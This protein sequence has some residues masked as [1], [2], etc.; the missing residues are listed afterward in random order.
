M[1]NAIILNWQIYFFSD[2]DLAVDSFSKLQKV[3]PYRLE[4]MD[5][6]SN[7]LYVKVSGEI[8]TENCLNAK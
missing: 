6:Y 8:H 3:D 5:V 1:I 2:V 4:N 7:L